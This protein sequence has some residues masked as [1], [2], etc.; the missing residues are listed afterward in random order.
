MGTLPTWSNAVS[1][2][3]PPSTTTDPAGNAYVKL[4]VTRYHRIS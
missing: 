3:H 1:A 2:P 4:D